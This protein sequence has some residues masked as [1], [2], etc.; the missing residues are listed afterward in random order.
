MR[1][2][3]AQLGPASLCT[4]ALGAPIPGRLPSARVPCLLP[5]SRARGLLTSGTH[6][7]SPSAL[8]LDVRGQVGPTLKP[9]P[10]VLS[11]LFPAPSLPERSWMSAVT[12]QSAF[13][14]TP[15]RHPGWTPL[16]LIGTN[17][18]PNTGPTTQSALRKHLFGVKRLFLE[19][20]M[21]THSR[22]LAWRIP[23]TEEPGGLQSTGSQNQ[24]RL[25]DY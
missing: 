1:I 2:K 23:W 18:G 14:G 10:C 21:A 9:V 6:T 5:D 3:P 22:I 25:S 15:Q 12:S 7:V 11:H 24:R 16:R 13:P 20:G 19:E 4:R 17:C 8:R